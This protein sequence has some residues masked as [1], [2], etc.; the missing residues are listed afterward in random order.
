MEF[1][2]KGK[3]ASRA[4]VQTLYLG[5]P[6]A[7]ENVAG[8]GGFEPPSEAPEAPVLSKLDYGPVAVAGSRGALRVRAKSPRD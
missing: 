4:Y 6:G 2:P 8:P 1:D 7:P 5:G 3:D